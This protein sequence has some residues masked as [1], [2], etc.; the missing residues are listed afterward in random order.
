MLT[1]LTQI[2]QDAEAGGYAVIAPDFTNLYTARV[3]LEAAERRGAPL[4][5]S[6]ASSF[7]PMREIR[8]YQRFIGAVREEIETCGIPACLHLDHA[9]SREE[10]QEAVEAGFNSVMIDASTAPWEDNLALTR[11]VVDYAHPLGVSVEAEL[12]QVTTGAGYFQSGSREETLTDPDQAAEFV[13]ETGI[14]ALAVAFGNAHGAYVG[15]P[16]LDFERLEQIRDRVD[17]PIVLHGASGI[18]EGDLRRA[19]SLG[20]RKINLYSEL[21]YSQHKAALAV[22]RETLMDPVGVARAQ[23]E[24]LEKVLGEFITWSGSGRSEA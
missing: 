17:L 19:V 10:I 3:L 9:E 20:I 8:S 15:E 14:D 13:A 2:L 23:A 18:P 1:S 6:Y 22:L 21:V 12:G 7:K 5:L 16:Q 24:G 4:I 11:E